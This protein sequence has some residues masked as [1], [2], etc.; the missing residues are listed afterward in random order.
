MIRFFL[1]VLK[2]CCTK[3]LFKQ[4]LSCSFCRYIHRFRNEPPKSRDERGGGVGGRGDEFWW[5]KEPSRSSTPKESDSS[6]FSPPVR[7]RDTLKGSGKSVRKP[8]RS[9]DT[10]S[11]ISSA[12]IMRNQVCLD[13]LWNFS[14]DAG[15][16]GMKCTRVIY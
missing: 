10:K 11:A 9:P 6:T 4:L 2:F 3:Y 7:L 5:T 12:K 13:F 8:P 14:A 16:E 15:E 1:A